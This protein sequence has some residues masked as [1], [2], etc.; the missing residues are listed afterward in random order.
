VLN[1]KAKLAVA[2]HHV[3]SLLCR[4]TSADHE[5][6]QVE[7]HCQDNS[8]VAQA[9]NEAEPP[10]AP[11]PDLRWRP[12]SRAMTSARSLLTL[13]AAAELPQRDGEALVGA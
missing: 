11:R 5:Q 10:A 6:L 2:C 1:H 7:I 13:A 8:E 9:R 12:P 4:R 3:L